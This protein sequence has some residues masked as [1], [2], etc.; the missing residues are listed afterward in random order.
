MMVDAIPSQVDHGNNRM[1]Q[2]PWRLVTAN[3]HQRNHLWFIAWSTG[4]S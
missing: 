4:S 3:I 1:H 2:P